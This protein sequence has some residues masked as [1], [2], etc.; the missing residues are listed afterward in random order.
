[1][2]LIIILVIIAL[3]AL[4]AIGTYNRLVRGKNQI[5]EAGAAVDSELKKR[6]DLIPNL[7]ET[8][9]GYAKHEQ[10]TLEAVIAARNSA[11]G[12]TSIEEK[13]KASSQVSGALKNL[14][15][16]AESY[17]DLKA[18]T[19]FLDLQKQL[20]AI[21]QDL[22]QARKYYN[23]V[24]KQMNNMVEV[25]PSNLVASLA[26]Y[27]KQPYMQIEEEARKRVEVKF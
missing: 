7:V 18:N 12:A 5:E 19:S 15:A 23:A 25:F 20:S 11:L 24:V 16:L 13:D 6:Y 3:V 17:P 21:E 1:M 4:Y 27:Q 14:F 9:K 22:N 10:G 8:V 26:H 2:A